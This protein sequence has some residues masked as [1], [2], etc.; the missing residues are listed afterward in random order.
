MLNDAPLAIYSDWDESIG[1]NRGYD[2]NDHIRNPNKSIWEHIK[3]WIAS[4]SQDK[5]RLGKT[6]TISKYGLPG[7]TWSEITLLRA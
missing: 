1:K 3:K 7:P 6:Y 2:D 4:E 5:S